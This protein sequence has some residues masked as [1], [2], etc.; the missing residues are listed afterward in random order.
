MKL[1]LLLIISCLSALS[2]FAQEKM[3]I[4]TSDKMTIGAPISVHDS[5]YFSEDA[6]I[7]FFRIGDTIAQFPLAV[8]DSITFADLPDSIMINYTGTGVSVF[9]PMAFE[10]VSIS[11]EGTDVTI[12]AESGLQDITYILSGNTPDGM[13]KIYSDKRFYLILNGIDITNT[14]GPAI[15]NQSGKNCHVIL[16]DGSANV[17]SDGITYAPP[18]LGEDQDG[19]FFSEGDLVFSGTG[20][21]TIHSFGA[22]QHGLSCDDEIEVNDGSITIT[23]AS[24]DGIHANNGILIAGGS[25]NVTSTGDG[26]D[27]D[28]GY[29]EILGGTVTTNN[30]SDNVNGISCDSTLSISGGIVNITVSGDQSKGIKCDT[31]ITLSGGIITIHNSGDAVLVPSGSGNDPS[32]CTAIK[33]DDEI[34]VS[35]A[36]ITIVASGK[37]GKGLSAD[38][39]ILI[40]DGSVTITS[41]G[42]GAVYTNTSGVADAYVSTC[43][44]AEGSLTIDGGTVTT[45]SSGSGG[46]GF[47]SNTQVKIGTADLE[48]TV[49]ITTSGT[50]ILISGSGQNANYA[51]A[52][53]VKSDGEVMLNKGNITISSSDDAIKSETS[54]VINEAT[55]TVSNSKEGLEAPYITFNGGNSHVK[56]S[57]DCLNATFGNGGE[58]DDGSLL[59]ITG[60]YVVVNT[61]GGDGLDSNGD[62]LITGGIVVTHGP[63][64][65]P[66]VGMDYNGQ[67]DMN[68]G[69]LV[70]SGT[71]SNMTQA[72]SSTS[73]QYCL[74][75]RANQSLSATTLFHIQDA[76]GNSILNFQPV[77]SYYSI[78]F[79]SADLHS[80]SSYSIYTGGTCTGTPT[81]GLYTGGTYSGGTFRKTFTI[82]G[83]ITSVNF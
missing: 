11:V 62:I 35:G 51:E 33:S 30:S 17:L 65:Q 12:Q 16:A 67:C 42:N 49:N 48:P 15:N 47:S 78:I 43:L 41:T 19:T 60:G 20:T 75:I 14:D 61:T 54:I 56:S 22:A 6:T 81:D 28:A 57:D 37:A 10:G 45:T 18:P 8:I 29:V 76:T 63:P 9:N 4:H 70:I 24:M 25:V 13:F 34:K 50:R 82:T 69:F 27:G 59:K 72:P 83:I 23:R 71:N 44:S 26:I 79:S 73:D 39:D 64:S 3:F 36:E 31:L 68:G 52:K 55:L 32:Y 58:Q 21:L 53:A 77:R 66:E 1:R 46:K 5:I 74:K 38:S 80:G 40:T 2:L 7:A